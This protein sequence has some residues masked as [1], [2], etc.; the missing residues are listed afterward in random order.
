MNRKLQIVILTLLL[1]AFLVSATGFRI[2]KHICTG[3][4][5]VEYVYN[6]NNS[7]CLATIQ[8]HQE[9]ADCCLPVHE[10]EIIT[11]SNCCEHESQF[12]VTDETLTGASSNLLPQPEQL[13]VL[14]QSIPSSVAA[15]IAGGV[16]FE[17]QTFSA[18]PSGKS[19]LI[20]IHQLKV[21][22]SHA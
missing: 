7:C 19:L 20:M 2:L 6:E 1:P 17:K 13:P 8:L 16:G 5:L 10:H 22:C 12:F 4:G 15:D 18:T 21:D 9:K 14:S 3:C 11:C